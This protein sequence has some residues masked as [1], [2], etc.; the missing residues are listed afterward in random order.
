MNMSLIDALDRH[1]NDK[2][3]Q[4]LEENPD[5][6]RYRNE[7]D[8]VAIHYAASD[9]DLNAL[10]LIFLAD[11][12]LVD[13]RD[14]TKQTPLLCAVMS[15]RI[16]NAEFL[17]NNGADVHAIDENGRN[18]VHW[19]VVSGQLESLN[20]S[21][22]KGVDLQAQ[23]NDVGVPSKFSIQNCSFQQEC[24]PLH[25]ATC[26]EDTPP[27]VSQAIIVTLLKHGA[28]PNPVDTDD[29]TPI[30]WCSSNG[31]LEAIKALY[32]SGGD[33]TCR[34]KQ[35]LNILH[36]AASH[37]YH[38]VIE[39]AIRNVDRPIIDDID[40]A[41]HSALFYAISFGHYEAALKLLQNNANPNHQDQRLATAA[42]SAASKGQM[43]MLKLLKQ[44]NASFDIQNYRGD[45]PFHEAVMVGSK[46]V[47]EWLLAVDESVLDI[48]NHSGRTALH[49]A[50][51]VGNLEMVIL[52]CTKKCFVD[53]LCTRDNEILTPLD[54][55]VRQR[56]EA[57]VEY[58]TK[59]C[60]AKRSSEFSAEYVENWKMNFEAMIAEAKRKRNEFIAEQKSKR[61]PS[62]SDGVVAS[63]RK[64]EIADVGVNT[65]QRSIKSA[66]SNTVKRK[67][68]K[69]TSVT[70]LMEVPSIPKK[71]LEALKE[72]I[73]NGQRLVDDDDDDLQNID[74]LDIDDEFENLPP[75]SD[76]SESSS[77]SDSEPNDTDDDADKSNDEDVA[78]K[79]TV[80]E[81]KSAVSANKKPKKEVRIETG[82]NGKKKSSTA[83]HG[84]VVMRVRREPEIG[85]DG[86][87][88][89]IYDDGEGQPSDD[90]EKKKEKE[91]EM[92]STS[93]VSNR[94]YV[95]ER[96]IFQELTH[97]KRM[98]IQ[99]GKVVIARKNA[100]ALLR[101]YYHPTEQV[102]EKVLV[103]SL[104][105]N[106]CKMHNL[107]VRNFKF[108]SFYA[109]E[110]FL[111]DALSEQ[112]KIIYLEERERLAETESEMK[113]SATMK[114]NKFDSKIR[115]SVPINDK[116]HDMQR[117]YTHAAIS[118]KS[119]S[120]KPRGSSAAPSKEISS[121]KRCD[122]LDKHKHLFL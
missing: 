109:W 48:P 108:T 87:D 95:H 57:V 86:G 119:T 35:N 14:G 68:S 33:L 71:E 15:G 41:G 50:A 1:E 90:E 59:L 66:D 101:N 114:L 34:D 49:L 79:V 29:R 61:R 31:N 20:W 85:S 54:L 110:R 82:K 43:R 26:N 117:I 116:F 52:L 56:H 27:E 25:Y 46:D 16:E 8:K 84:T 38:E 100:K 83:S 99:Y 23:D 19:S 3:Q 72:S 65:S 22:A 9:G 30:H 70:N 4:I 103:R 64:R 102:Q 63:E 45:L 58:L 69:S 13:V 111:Y 74:M 98:Q 106:F 55:A 18:A 75:I 47:V 2:I 89:D 122:C 39:F 81:V 67:Y 53:P 112:L 5:E 51:S 80:Q 73:E 17:A 120:S 42:H 12:T 107:D 97:L 10:K 96:A 37:G 88:V 60:R 104:I 28:K 105:S 44:F 76:S 32:N 36:C 6:V 115:N 77:S 7:E 93:T 40:K 62:T 118:H 121:R 78:R 21:I 91:K 94:R 11:R 24:T 113:P 92:E